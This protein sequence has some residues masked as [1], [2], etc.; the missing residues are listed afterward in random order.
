MPEAQPAPATRE[1]LIVNCG[2]SLSNQIPQALRDRKFYVRVVQNLAEALKASKNLFQ[3]ILICEAGSNPQRLQSCMEELRS[4]AVEISMPVVLVG[5]EAD[6]FERELDSL[7]PATTTLNLPYSPNELAAAVAYICRTHLERARRTPSGRIIS[8]LFE[9]PGTST[10]ATRDTTT[11][12][13][14]GETKTPNLIFNQ[15][16]K[17]SLFD[18]QLGGQTFSSPKLSTEMLA[19]E[20]LLPA[21]PQALGAVQALCSGAGQWG[22]L[23]LARTSF[24]AQ[25]IISALNPDES[26]KENIRVCGFLYAWSFGASNPLLLQRPYYDEDSDPFRV[27]LCSRIKDSAMTILS[28]LKMEDASKVVATMARLVGKEQAP[29]DDDISVTASALMAADL[30]SRVCYFGGPWN[31]RKAY[32]FLANLK[33]NPPTGIHPSVLSCTV[34]IIAEALSS[35]TPIVVLRKDIRFNKEALAFIRSESKKPLNKG[36]RRVALASLIPGMRLSQ[37][38]RSLDG[39]EILSPDLTLDED[40][41]WRL[42]Q[43]AAIRPLYHPIIQ[44]SK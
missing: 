24:M 12:A 38:L 31:S 16:S 3:P 1:V 10:T 2:G 36:E 18:K 39:Q 34:K 7:F 6:Q 30:S 19:E 20:G 25:K 43:L 11:P 17:L 33:K 23:Q 29:E 32:S 35:R 44:K 37:P 27:E 26:L 14:D 4:R 22:Q 8:P 28:N 41:I 9:E 15:L 5:V 40:L 13:L 42:W 21:S